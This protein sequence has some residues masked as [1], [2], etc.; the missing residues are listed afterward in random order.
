MQVIK[1]FLKNGIDTP[2]SS[3][4]N[5]S[6]NDNNMDADGSSNSYVGSSSQKPAGAGNSG[7]HGSSGHSSRRRNSMIDGTG[8]SSGQAGGGS[9]NG[10]QA[11]SAG[12]QQQQQQ[13]RIEEGSAIAAAGRAAAIPAWATAAAVSGLVSPPLLSATN[14]SAGGN[15]PAAAA[16]GEG[17]WPTGLDS[18]SS[19]KLDRV[20][21]GSR[22]GQLDPEP[23]GC[24]SP[25]A[26]S[27]HSV[28]TATGSVASTSSAVPFSRIAYQRRQQKRELEL[29]HNAKRMVND[30]AAAFDMRM[31]AY[32]LDFE[33]L[34]QLNAA[35]AE[36]YSSTAEIAAAL[37]QFVLDLGSRQTAVREALAALPQ[38][39]RQLKL[40]EAAVGQLNKRSKELEA[41]VGLSG[42][43]SSKNAFEYL[44]SSLSRAGST[45][46]SVGAAA[47]GAG[48]CLG[49]G[50]LPKQ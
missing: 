48:A 43:S 14:S 42:S 3:V 38:L 36:Q 1:H 23:S 50:A 40:L 46:S 12:T 19:I 21:G 41:S 39:D 27:E 44:A 26:A 29:H 24:S 10:A 4:A 25:T 47:V 33:A 45:V 16:A 32:S 15:N 35:A 8:A 6:S 37:G 18:L 31:E 9:S 7:G 28:A 30:A 49:G 2:A 22:S 5:S 34:Q 20:G 13:E 11:D 17:S